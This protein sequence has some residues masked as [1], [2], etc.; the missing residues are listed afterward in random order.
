MKHERFPLY[1]DMFEPFVE[2]NIITYGC[3]SQAPQRGNV[4]LL[5][6]INLKTKQNVQKYIPASCDLILKA[7]WKW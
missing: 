3:Q 1:R 5:G 6:K 4:R 7:H 2:N